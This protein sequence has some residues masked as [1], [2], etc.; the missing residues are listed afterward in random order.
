M[1]FIVL[2]IALFIAE[3]HQDIKYTNFPGPTERRVYGYKPA[4]NGRK[5]RSYSVSPEM[6]IK[7]V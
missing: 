5:R 2:V 1:P 3:S 6:Y 7:K 4:K